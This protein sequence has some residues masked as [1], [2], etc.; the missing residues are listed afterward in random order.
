MQYARKISLCT[1]IWR[2]PGFTASFLGIT[3]HYFKRN[4]KKEYHYYLSW[5]VCLLFIAHI[6]LVCMLSW[7]CMHIW[8]EEIV[9]LRKIQSIERSSLSHPLIFPRLKLTRLK[10]QAIEGDLRH[11]PTNHVT[12]LLYP[13]TWIAVS[14]KS[15]VSQ[16]SI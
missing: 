2:K 6:V 10:N 11:R 13:L 9:D 4:G 7:V 14:L 12:I 5:I 1:D 8:R 3:C 15:S 16:L